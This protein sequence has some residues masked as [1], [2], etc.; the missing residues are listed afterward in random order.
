[1]PVYPG[2]PTARSIGGVT[3]AAL[4]GMFALQPSYLAPYSTPTGQLVLVAACCWFL[5][6][7]WGLSRLGRPAR[8][9]RLSLREVTL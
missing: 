9:R 8:P 4:A 2:A 5:L 1:M 6:G 3:V 7:F